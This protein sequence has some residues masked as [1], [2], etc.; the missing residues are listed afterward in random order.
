MNDLQKI[1]QIE[2]VKDYTESY[3]LVESSALRD[4][5]NNFTFIIWELKM[6]L[7]NEIYAEGHP[8]E[9]ATVKVQ[10]IVDMKMHI[11]RYENILERIKTKRPK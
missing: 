4:V 10:R 1:P 7:Q 8:N 9:T 2:P 3:E 6:K 11:L 5:I